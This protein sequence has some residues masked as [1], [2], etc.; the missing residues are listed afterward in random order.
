MLRFKEY[1]DIKAEHWSTLKNLAKSPLHYLYAKQNPTEDTVSLARGRGVHTAVLEPEKFDF[2]YII[3][4][5]KARRGKEWDAFK[6]EHVNQTIL[7]ADERDKV[8]AAADAVRRHPEV[9]ALMR[10]GVSE[11]SFKWLDEESGLT[12]K[13][14]V[15]WIGDALFDLKTTGDVDQRRFGNV[16]AR[17]MYHGQV[18]MYSDGAGHRGDIFIVAVEAE[19]PYDVAVFR[20]TE[21]A[22]YAGRELYR[23]FLKLA[24]ECHRTN[25]WPGRFPRIVDL[26]L[27]RYVFEDEDQEDGTSVVITD[28]EEVA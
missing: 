18:G 19:P 4:P 22:L 3:Y 11:Q 17:L 21:D 13:S 27:P 25:L 10:S 26:E 5:G 20:V 15:D 24:A 2:E 28:E 14:R 9:K 12:C 8:L 7:K 16:A 1:V 23:G 6:A